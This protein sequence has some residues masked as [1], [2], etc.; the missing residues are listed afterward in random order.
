MLSYLFAAA[1]HRALL[2]PMLPPRKLTKMP[3]PAKRLLPLPQT[4]TVLR[5]RRLLLLLPSEPPPLLVVLT[6]LLP[7]PT[8]PVKLTTM[9]ASPP[10]VSNPSMPPLWP[11]PR[12]TPM[13]PIAF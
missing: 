1:R 6:N 4:T 13:P 3:V 12:P 8:L 10:K 5:L 2:L 11:T 7:T 9:L